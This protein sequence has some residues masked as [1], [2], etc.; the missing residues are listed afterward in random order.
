[1]NSVLQ[2]VISINKMKMPELRKKYQELFNEEPSATANRR[3]LVPKIA[4]QIQ[5]LAFG[6]L[7]SK[8]IR[9]MEEINKGKTPDYARPKNKLT[10]P[11][12]TVIIKEYHGQTYRIRVT[13][14][15]FVMN[16][17]HYP[18]LAQ[19]ARTITGGT[20]WNAK[21]FFKLSETE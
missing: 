21:R 17:I 6:G 3:H 11:A 1:M 15:D 5:A 2:E 20:N 19:I 8:A 12:G 16:E 9:M 13:D 18:S 7:S 10:L 14:T 4:Y